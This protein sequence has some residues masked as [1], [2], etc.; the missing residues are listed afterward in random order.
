MKTKLISVLLVTLIGH[1]CA[2]FERNYQAERMAQEG[3]NITRMHQ[4][5]YFT[6][7]AGLLLYRITV[8]F[9]F[10]KQGVTHSIAEKFIQKP[11]II[12]EHISYN[13]ICPTSD[14]LKCLRQIP[15]VHGD[16][17]EEKALL[18]RQIK[19]LK[20]PIIDSEHFTNNSSI[21]HKNLPCTLI[22]NTPCPQLYLQSD[23]FSFLLMLAALTPVSNTVL[24]RLAST[25]APHYA[26][27]QLHSLYCAMHTRRSALRHTSTAVTRLCISRLPLAIHTAF[28]ISRI[29]SFLLVSAGYTFL[30]V[31]LPFS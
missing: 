20:H 11:G 21:T 17:Q 10:R 12:L 31:S 9:V 2:F 16:L 4:M 19:Q 22:F 6:Y 28:C 24:Q 1:E 26:V 30:D 25:H 14:V 7:T 29:F 18:S 5:L 8:S 13:N 23:Q 27:P 15:V 3:I